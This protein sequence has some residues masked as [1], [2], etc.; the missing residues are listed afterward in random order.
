MATFPVATG[1]HLLGIHLCGKASAFHRLPSRS[2]LA[3]VEGPPRHPSA[4]LQADLGRDRPTDDPA[5]RA[6]GSHSPV[7]HGF[8]L[9]N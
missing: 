7:S 1:A 6:G 4:P 8:A 5:F 9:S 2:P 3:L